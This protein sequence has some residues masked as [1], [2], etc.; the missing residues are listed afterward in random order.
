MRKNVPR[1]KRNANKENVNDES[2]TKRGGG[3]EIILQKGKQFIFEKRENTNKDFME[4]EGTCLG[5][6]MKI[7]LVYFDVDKTKEGEKINAKLRKDIE[8]RME[9]KDDEGLIILGDFNGHIRGL[10]PHETDFNGKMILEWMS[11]YS[12]I[13]LNMDEK[14]QGVTTWSRDYKNQHSAVDFVLVNNNIYKKFCNMKIDE[15]KDVL[16]I[17][18]H[19]LVTFSLNIE[20]K[21]NNFNK[22][23][24]EITE[25]YTFKIE[26]LKEFIEEVEKRWKIHKI[27]NI[28]EMD[29]SLKECADAILK[30]IYK[31]RIGTE[32]DEKVSEKPW[33]TEEIRAEIKKKRDLNRRKR[34]CNNNEEKDYLTREWKKQK[35]KAKLKIREAIELYEVKLTNEIKDKNNRGKLLWE[36]INKLRGKEKS[37]IKNIIYD[38]N[39]KAL[40]TDTS[41]EKILEFWKNLYNQYVNNIDDIW[42]EEIKQDLLLQFEE[43]KKWNL[44]ILKEHLDMAGEVET[45]IIPMDLIDSEKEEVKED[46]GRL[47]NKKAAGPSKLKG[48][49]YKEVSSSIFCLG[50]MTDCLNK[51]VTEDKK[52]ENRKSSRTILVP[53]KSKPT[54]KDLRPIAVTNISYKLCMTKINRELENHLIKNNLVKENQTGFTQ[55][56]RCEYNHLILHYLV[57][58]AFINK[59]SLFL[60]A[61]DFR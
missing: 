39:G 2:K 56:G 20:N 44:N 32:N 34:N 54:E 37:V 3:L 24:Y 9:V 13:L 1:N 46:V 55:G 38:K 14:C 60:I 25:Y 53:K 16:D 17:S 27:N 50:V 7:I 51:A 19:H 31:K 8:K 12:L 43:E 42:N 48:E 6:K 33:F 49:L 45:K 52:P 41:K 57:E 11:N 26:A 29:I 59:N 40:N 18:D 23:Q 61:I 21:N 4:I 30:R 28:E 5:I 47:K 22:K 35:D 15:K 10:G 36:N 58:K